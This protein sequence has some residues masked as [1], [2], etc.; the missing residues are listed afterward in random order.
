MV[1]VFELGGEEGPLSGPP[2]RYAEASDSYNRWTT[3][4]GS[5]QEL[6]GFR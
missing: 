2:S 3:T 1:L 6:V 4:G 5:A